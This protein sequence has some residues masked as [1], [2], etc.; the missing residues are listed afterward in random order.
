MNKL[1]ALQA[2]PR[3]GAC[4]LMAVS[5]ALPPLAF[6]SANACVR[7]LHDHGQRFSPQALGRQA[8]TEVSSTPNAND[9]G[10]PIRWTKTSLDGSW[11]LTAECR[12]CPAGKTVTGLSL[13][14]KRA[15]PCGLAH[16]LSQAAVVKLLGP[17]DERRGAQFVY[18]YPPT[19]RNQAM[20]LTFVDDQLS[21]TQW[22]F[23]FE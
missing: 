1:P 6:A 13:T 7:K 3:W 8:V 22:D 12:S 17:P 15:L 23:Y 2:S 19:E 16:G 9:P 18:L 5:L 14:G 20:T 11:V 10:H 21:S 4:L